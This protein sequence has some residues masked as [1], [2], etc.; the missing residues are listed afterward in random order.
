MATAVDVLTRV[1]EKLNDIG[2]VRWPEAEHYRAIKDA[3]LAIL[4]ALPDLFEVYAYVSTI[5]GVVQSVPADCYKLFDVVGNA[6]DSDKLISPA[7]LIERS[8]LDRQRR[9][10]MAMDAANEADHWMQDDRER[11]QFFIVPGQPSSDR[12]K[13]YLRYA[14]YPDTVSA[15]G[16]TLDV[17]DEGINAVY[18]FCMHRALEKDEKF[19]GS[20]QAQSYMKKFALF[21]NARFEADD[22]AEA[23]RQRREDP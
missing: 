14:K 22:Q 5:E 2:S 16:D 17:A 8:T 21:L 18:N 23:D 20:P 19:S 6:N 10:W 11:G 3:Q 4:E 7:T 12:G 13:L 9:N 1:K 15:S